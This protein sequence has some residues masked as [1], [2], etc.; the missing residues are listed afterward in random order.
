MEG[1]LKKNSSWIYSVKRNTEKEIKF[2]EK[3]RKKLLEKLVCF[4]ELQVLKDPQKS[5][6]I[7]YIRA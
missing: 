2:L 7:E 4:W 5:Q 3:L 1:F 6:E